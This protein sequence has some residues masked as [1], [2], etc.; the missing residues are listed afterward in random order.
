MKKP[1]IRMTIGLPASGKSSAARQLIGSSDDWVQVE[2]DI[3]RKESNLFDGGEYNHQRGDE[4]IV[5]RERNKRIREAIRSGKSVIVSDCNLDPRHRSQLRLIATECGVDLEVDNSFL[6]VPLLKCVERDAEREDSVGKDVILDMYYKHVHHEYFSRR[7]DW[8]ERLNRAYVID[9]D[10]ALSSKKFGV[11]WYS[12]DGID[13]SSPNI[14]IM[15]ILDAL[16]VFSRDDLL[17]KRTKYDHIIIIS[18]TRESSRSIAEKWLDEHE[19][20]YDELLMR[21]DG[22]Y[23]DEAEV[24]RDLYNIYIKKKY[25][26]VAVFEG[27]KAATD[28]WRRDL[29]L[30]VFHTHDEYLKP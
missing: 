10:T 3:I 24:K 30:M 4:A 27:S 5:V 28:M 18:G 21:D 14:A 19:I 22:D 20:Y 7:P 16:D 26:V 9:L 13:F 8:K 23:R 15:H 12:D 17:K 1:V 11:G 25:D 2:K 6:D 29:G